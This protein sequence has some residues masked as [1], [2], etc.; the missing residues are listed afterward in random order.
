MVVG[1]LLGLLE[2]LLDD[3]R[4]ILDDGARSAQQRRGAMR[5]AWWWVPLEVA[6]L[7][8]EALLNVKGKST[9]SE[10]GGG[11]SDRRSPKASSSKSLPSSS[12]LPSSQGWGVHTER[13]RAVLERVCMCAY[14]GVH[15][16]H[17][18]ALLTAEQQ[19]QQAMIHTAPSNIFNMFAQIDEPTAAVGDAVGDTVGDAHRDQSYAADRPLEARKELPM[20]L[21][22][23]LSIECAINRVCY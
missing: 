20:M 5:G 6:S 15:Y 22:Q 14:E 13:A 17:H 1:V 3:G 18:F 23:V 4:G 8:G 21:H 7:L 2:R 11:K 19:K 16:A 12:R 10:S 9:A